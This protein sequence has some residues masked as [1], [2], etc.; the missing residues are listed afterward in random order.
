MKTLKQMAKDF[1]EV[2]RDPI[3]SYTAYLAGYTA[4]MEKAQALVDE[5][6]E[7]P[8]LWF[9]AEQFREA[10]LQQ[11]LRRLHAVIEGEK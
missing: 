1:G 7:D 8:G 5:Q 3:V 9:M 6:A 2:S 4:A 10:H 11:E